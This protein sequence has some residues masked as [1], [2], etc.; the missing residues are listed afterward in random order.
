MTK[1][2]PILFSGAMVR[3]ILDGRKTQ[4]RRVAKVPADA[5]DV[6]YWAPPCGRSQPGWANPGL[7]YWTPA[8][9]GA[10]LSNHLDACPYGQPG[11]RLWVRET[12]AQPASLDPGPTV[13]RADYPACVPPGFENIPPAKAIIWKPSIHMPRAACR[14]RLEITGVRVERLNDCSE[15]DAVAEGLHILPAS[16][17]YVVSPGE[18]YF[19]L[20]DHDPRAVYADLWDRINGAGAWQLNPWVWAIEFRRI[21]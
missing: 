17:R 7:N 10:T 12:W 13:Y 1:E 3:A 6:R 4:T 2:R 21:D 20:A 14:L 9:S 19:G 16:G 8:P 11:E 18:Q 5:T 15:S